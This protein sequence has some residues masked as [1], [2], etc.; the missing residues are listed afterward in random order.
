[1]PAEILKTPVKR[2]LTFP[3]KV[4]EG[5][6]NEANKSLKALVSTT[7]PD[8][9]GSIILPS[10]WQ[11][12]NY[13]KNPLF[14]WQ[15]EWHGQPEDA[16][17][18]ALSVNPVDE[19]LEAEPKYCTDIN[20]KAD[21]VWKLMQAGVLKAFSPGFYVF[22]WIDQIDVMLAD[23]KMAEKIAALPDWAKDPLLAGEIWEV[24]LSA[25]LIEI[26]NVLIGSNPDALWDAVQNGIL[27]REMA[28]RA[29][30]QLGQGERAAALRSLTN[31]R[32]RVPILGA[33]K[34]ETVKTNVQS[35]QT[36]TLPPPNA[37]EVKGELLE[38]EA[39]GLVERMAT[40]ERKLDQLLAREP[41]E[42]KETSGDSTEEETKEAG[43]CPHC[44][45]ETTTCSEC[46]AT[47]CSSVDACPFCGASM[48]EDEAEEE[49]TEEESDEERSLDALAER[50]T[51]EI[52]RELL[53]K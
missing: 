42:E 49:S 19:G 6:V 35:T 31:R 23:E 8:R 22:D 48:T 1:M 2:E 10:A 15:H 41:E 20:P 53:K 12:D 7:S 32:P 18:T 50:M 39:E 3:V 45:G 38:V 51:T 46:S 30:D 28:G 14:L 24:I 25:E 33:R 9:H 43:G 4:R 34:E 36:K 16:I 26:S 27:P 11:L 13:R 37:E 44:A 21:M 29:L 5:S 40:I 52:M 17:G 47:V